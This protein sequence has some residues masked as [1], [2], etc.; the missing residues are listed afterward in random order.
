[1]LQWGRGFSAAEFSRTQYIGAYEIRLQWGRGF[2]AAE[3]PSSQLP[4]VPP[5]RGGDASGHFR[6]T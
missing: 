6:K 3:F 1:M 5:F 4:M 2:S